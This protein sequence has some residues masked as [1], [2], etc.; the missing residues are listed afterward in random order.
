M[1]KCRPVLV[2]T[3]PAMTRRL[4]L[5]SRNL[6]RSHQKALPR[7]VS[8]LMRNNS[9]HPPEAILP[10]ETIAGDTPINATAQ[11]LS[12]P[13]GPVF[14]FFETMQNKDVAFPTGLRT[15]P[16]SS[17][18]GKLSGRERRIAALTRHAG[19]RYR[20]VNVHQ[21][22]EAAGM[23]QPDG[24]LPSIAVFSTSFIA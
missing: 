20:R 12:F 3:L 15:W 10:E 22:S 14:C 2:K 21:V 24:E 1:A 19:N 13:K 17:C 18:C 4:P 16:I 6:R 7:L 8:D 5:F 9:S 11:A 23:T